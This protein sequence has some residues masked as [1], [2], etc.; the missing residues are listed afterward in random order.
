[1]SSK[2]DSPNRQVVIIAEFTFES[3]AIFGWIFTDWI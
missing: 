3:Q 2:K 1:M